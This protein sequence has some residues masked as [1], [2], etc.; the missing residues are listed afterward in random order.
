M[1]APWARASF[2]WDSIVSWVEGI[3]DTQRGHGRHEA[4]GEGIGHRFVDDETLGSNTRLP[5]VLYPG[6]HARRDRPSQ[7]GG[8][9]HN[10]W[11]TPP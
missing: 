4:A 8:G 2:T 5:I 7:I 3:A 10:K 6:L 11:V 1:V 9:E